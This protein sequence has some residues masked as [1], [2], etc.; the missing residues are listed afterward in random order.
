MSSN[1]D[2]SLSRAPAPGVALRPGMSPDGWPAPAYLPLSGRHRMAY[3]LVGHA[4]G[5]PWLLLHGGPGGA[6]QPGMLRPLDLSRQWAIAPD[7]RGCGASRPKGRTQ[8]NHTAALVADLEALRRHLGLER[9]HLLAG[10]WGTVVALA[11]AREHPQRVGRVVLRAAFALSR[12]EIGG[13]VMPPRR[14]AARLGAA[15]FWPVSANHSVPVVL[16]RLKQVLQSGTPSVAALRVARRWQL[17]E[18]AC[19]AAG[20]RRTLRH[21]TG[22]AAGAQTATARREWAA[23]QRRQRRAQARATRPGVRPGDRAA[24]HACRIQC[25]Y[26]LHHG[27]QRPG[28]LDR[29]VLML[30]QA[31]VPVDW[32]HGR[33]DA[34]C[35]PRNSRR[36]AALGARQAG[37]PVTLVEPMSGHLGHEPGMLQALRHRVRAARGSVGTLA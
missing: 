32:V 16:S 24:L 5:E 17:L 23:L 11:Y 3:R 15:P 21:L 25:H 6:C 8:G 36:W 33:F 31:G 30:A 1:I 9:W 29:A 34:I 7:Q 18:S 28:D 37:G 26:L 12:R 14:V 13:L 35:P 2:A 10:S 4:S 22:P 19:A 27:F 20:M